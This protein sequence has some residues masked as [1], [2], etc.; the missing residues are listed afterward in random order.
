VLHQ[1][2]H[3]NRDAIIARARAKVAARPAPRATAEE[4]QT[5]IPLFLEQLIETLQGSSAAG[6]AISDS[7]SR[8]GEV[9][10]HRGFTVAQVVHDYGGVCQ[11]VTELADET[12]ASITPDEFHTFNRCLDDAIAHAVT[13]YSRQREQSL[14]DL[15]TER[16]GELAHELRNALGVAM[17][18]FQTLRTGTVGYGGSTSALLGRSLGR[19]STLLD[20]SL[21]QVRLD[22]KVHTQERVSVREFIEEVEVGAALEANGRGMT[23]S[24]KTVEPGVVVLA[25]RQLLAA[26]VANVLQNAFKFTHPHGH[27]TLRASSTKERVLVEVEDECGG[28]PTGDTEELFRPFEQRSD[29]RTGLGLGLPITRRSIEANGGEIRIR[30]LPG[31]GCVVT[32]DLPRLATAL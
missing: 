2:L 17:L 7:A 11:A 12:K 23:L 29:N 25:D 32:I 27:V 9:L 8:H 21:A 31:V 6:E 13:E 16:L 19:L 3:A 4:L 1:F 5:G 20:S 24:V 15:G 14:T 26:A 30:D 10:L 28:L 22:G 18:A